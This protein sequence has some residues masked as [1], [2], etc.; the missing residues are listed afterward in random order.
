MFIKNNKNKILD[1]GNL[2]LTYLEWYEKD[3]S[4]KFDNYDK[5][6]KYFETK[7]WLDADKLTVDDKKYLD[8]LKKDYKAKLSGTNDD[9]FLLPI[10][11]LILSN[12][13]TL[14]KPNNLA[15][16]VEFEDSLKPLYDLLFEDTDKNLLLGSA[17]EELAW[18]HLQAASRRRARLAEAG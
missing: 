7:A 2:I 1:D 6:K 5:T 17:K 15:L 9:A 16:Y 4:T 11:L 18:L 10:E 13:L 14:K 8:F 12:I 3:F